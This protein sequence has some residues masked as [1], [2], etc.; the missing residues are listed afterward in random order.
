VDIDAKK[1]TADIVIIEFT[2]RY[3]NASVSVDLHCGRITLKIIRT[4]LMPNVCPTL[5]KFLFILH[6]ELYISK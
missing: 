6:R 3:E 1:D 4:L 5:S 2:K